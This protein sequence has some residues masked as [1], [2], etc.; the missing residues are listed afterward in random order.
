ML[1]SLRLL[2]ANTS[3]ASQVLRIHANRSYYFS[4][5]QPSE[6]KFDKLNRTPKTPPT[7]KAAPSTEKPSDPRI[8]KIQPVKHIDETL[9]KTV[10]ESKKRYLDKWWLQMSMDYQYNIN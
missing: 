5:E 1:R 2:S 9:Q 7:P 10:M 6:P 3:I 4:A 8:G